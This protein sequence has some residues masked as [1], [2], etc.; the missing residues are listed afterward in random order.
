MERGE[1]LEDLSTDG[2]VLD[3]IDR[4][5]PGPDVKSQP[6]H[7]VN[8]QGT[9]VI[10]KGVPADREIQFF[11]L[12]DY[13]GKGVG[14]D[15]YDDY[16]YYGES[17]EGSGDENG[18][19]GMSNL[20]KALL[21]AELGMVGKKVHGWVR[22]RNNGS[23]V[24]DQSTMSMKAK[25]AANRAK[26]AGKNLLKRIGGKMRGM[27]N[28]VMKGKVGKGVKG[29]KRVLSKGVKMGKIGV[30]MVQKV[31]KMGLYLGKIGRK[32]RAIEEEIREMRRRRRQA[33][34]IGATLLGG[35]VLNNEWEWIK[36]E[37][38]IGSGTVEKGLV[39]DVKGNDD[40]LKILGTHVDLSLIH[41]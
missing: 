6:D 25:G 7:Q 32:K 23:S 29:V 17:G 13:Q 20:E 11:G 10:A 5:K 24:G 15:E 37:L 35:Y 26:G 14:D 12:P 8:L 3:E 36:D 34:A 22:G 30:P 19:G 1:I 4:R 18:G 2:Q 41:I 38:G 27:K 9:G 16:E 33:I 39:H 31:A 40:H 28:A 21:A